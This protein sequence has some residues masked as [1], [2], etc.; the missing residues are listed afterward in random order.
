M[1]TFWSKVDKTGECWV[2]VAGRFV[3]GYGAYR[4]QGAHRVSWGLM[5]GPIPAGLFVLH[6]CDNPPCV[7]PDHLFLGTHTDNMHDKV[8]KGRASG[9]QLTHCPEGHEYT[10]ENTYIYPGRTARKCRTCHR[11]REAA[12]RART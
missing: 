8:A 6:R 9:Q 5:N 11:I 1:E 4:N 10:V 12:R 3:T 2:W 7:R